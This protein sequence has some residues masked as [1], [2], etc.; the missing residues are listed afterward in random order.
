[1]QFTKLLRFPI[2]SGTTVPLSEFS[3]AQ[4]TADRV[5]K[6]VMDRFSE[7]ISGHTQHSRRKVL[8]GVV[9]SVDGDAMEDLSIITVS[10]GTKCVNGEHMSDCG[11]ALNGKMHALLTIVPD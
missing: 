7:L 1:M 10:T 3:L 9:M 5:G 4:P 2:W 11:N 6:L 8:A